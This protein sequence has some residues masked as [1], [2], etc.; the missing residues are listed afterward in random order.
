MLP[1]FCP[2]GAIIKP[3]DV[4]CLPNEGM[5][6]YRSP[7]QRGKLIIQFQV[8]RP[9]EGPR[10]A[11]REASVRSRAWACPLPPSGTPGPLGSLPL[12]P[13]AG[14][15]RGGEGGCGRTGGGEFQRE[16]PCPG[17]GEGSTGGTPPTTLSLLPLAQ[18]KFP[19]AGW[20]PSHQL[21]Q[22]QAFFP[23]REEVMA[24]EDTEEV[25]L[26]EYFPRLDHGRPFTG[27]A[28]QEEEFEDPARHHVQ[29]QTS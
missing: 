19:E 13:A 12:F 24:T 20:L 6:V 2:L 25:E 15:G 29:C 5:P 26:R 28:Y 10:L 21:R 22:F 9:L 27:E 4:K 3:G 8:W 7:T 14:R 16:A 18:V 1:F 11:F 17:H 23:R